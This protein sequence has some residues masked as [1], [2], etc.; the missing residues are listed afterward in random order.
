MNNRRER[1][2][3]P[4]L[5]AFDDRGDA[6][7]GDEED[8]NGPGAEGVH[9]VLHGVLRILPRVTVGD[10]WVS[11]GKVMPPGLG[12]KPG[13]HRPRQPPSFALDPI[14]RI[15]AHQRADASVGLE[16]VWTVRSVASVAWREIK[17]RPYR[18]RAGASQHLL[19]PEL[20]VSLARFGGCV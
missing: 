20:S 16:I 1:V 2:P 6:E 12:D 17:N 11:P 8:E 13:E 14:S 3:L 18:G 10:G 7:E 5:E 15:K 19:L 9:E 4:P